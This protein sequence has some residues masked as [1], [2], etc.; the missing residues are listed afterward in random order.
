VAFGHHT[1]SIEIPE[2][3]TKKK[4]DKEEIPNT[5]VKVQDREVI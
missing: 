3:S 1:V 4:K 5:L 2:T